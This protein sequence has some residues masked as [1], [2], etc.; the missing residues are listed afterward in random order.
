MQRIEGGQPVNS[1]CEAFADDL[2]VLFKLVGDAL[3]AILGILDNFSTLSGLAINREK[4]HILVSGRNW[5]GGVQ[6]RGYSG[7]KRM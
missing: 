1:L 3:K 6:Y 7:K 5:E 4:T 2:T